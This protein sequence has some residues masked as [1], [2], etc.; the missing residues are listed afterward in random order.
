MR[1]LKI[2]VE[3]AVDSIEEATELEDHY[4]EEAA[5]EGYSLT[6]CGV[7]YKK[8][9]SKGVVIAEQW[10]VKAVKTYEDVWDYLSDEE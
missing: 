10:V 3:T 1:T 9:K 6:D 7:T 8:K 5:A 2:T 4:K